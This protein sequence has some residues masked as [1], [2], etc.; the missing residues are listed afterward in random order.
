MAIYI[1]IFSMTDHTQPLQGR[2]QGPYQGANA[3]LQTSEV[4][5]GKLY[6]SKQTKAPQG[7]L[8]TD[9]LDEAEVILGYRHSD[10]GVLYGTSESLIAVKDLPWTDMPGL[11]VLSENDDKSVT[12]KLWMQEFT[13]VPGPVTRIHFGK[14]IVYM[15]NYGQVGSPNWT[16]AKLTE[17]PAQLHAEDVSDDLT[18]APPEGSGFQVKAGQEVAD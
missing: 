7:E 12:L 11:E 17:G 14:T 8:D 9:A 2:Y 10:S 15:K 6:L 5:D 16:D 4:K 3:D 1:Q 13:I 18:I